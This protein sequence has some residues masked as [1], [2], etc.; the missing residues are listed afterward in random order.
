[1]LSDINKCR[2]PT[3]HPT[4]FATI[5]SFSEPELRAVLRFM[6]L[7]FEDGTALGTACR[8]LSH[9]LVTVARQ[10]DKR[11]GRGD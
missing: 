6:P 1:M 7:D 4:S 8:K 9:G 5:L 11:L 2:E 3:T 10:N